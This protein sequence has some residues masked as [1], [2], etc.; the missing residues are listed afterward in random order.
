M[1]GATVL[2]GQTPPTPP[3]SSLGLDNQPKTT[4][5]ATHGAGHICGRRWP[6]WTSVGGEALRPEC[7]QCPSVGE[8]QGGRTGVGEWV[9]EHPHGGRGR[10]DGI[11]GF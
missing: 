7:I 11:G 9:K 5:G 8:C 3:P 1:E 6:C 2:S 10:G 4:H